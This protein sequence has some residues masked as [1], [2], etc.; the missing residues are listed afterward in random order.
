MTIFAPQDDFNS[1]DLKQTLH[2][3]KDLI[4]Y[5]V[6]AKKKE[7]LQEVFDLPSSFTYLDSHRLEVLSIENHIQTDDNF[8]FTE[9]RNEKSVFR[10][11]LK[12]RPF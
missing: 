8:Y 1:N 7:I 6:C 10:S 11:F 2:F 12:D 5:A 3:L 9:R 4:G